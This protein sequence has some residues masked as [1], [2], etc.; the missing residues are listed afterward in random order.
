MEDLITA[1]EIKIASKEQNSQSNLQKIWIKA[2]EIFRDNVDIAAFKIW[3]EQIEPV[4]LLGNKIVLRVPSQ[5]FYEWLEQHYSQL[6]QLTLNRIALKE[7]E[8][9]YEIKPNAKNTPNAKSNNPLKLKSQNQNNYM[10]PDN[11]N[12]PINKTL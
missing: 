10:K 6:I 5:F 2:L 4:S 12:N 11:N 8:I 9:F 1:S 7:I 3:F